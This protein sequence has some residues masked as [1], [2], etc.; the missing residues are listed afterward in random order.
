MIDDFSGGDR[1]PKD[2]FRQM[3]KI[4]KRKY[5][6]SSQLSQLERVSLSRIVLQAIDPWD[7]LL[8]EPDPSHETNGWPSF[9]SPASLTPFKKRFASELGA[10]LDLRWGR[11]VPL[12]NCNLALCCS[13]AL[14]ATT[15]VQRLDHKIPGR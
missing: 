11:R 2:V 13:K 12:L 1:V 5:N 7:E 10:F 15:V 9:K 6:N 8:Q 4:Y 3:L 14:A